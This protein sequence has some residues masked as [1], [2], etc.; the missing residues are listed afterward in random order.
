MVCSTEKLIP[1]GSAG[2]VNEP[3]LNLQ[4]IDEPEKKLKKLICEKQKDGNEEEEK[5]HH[6]G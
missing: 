2:S 1:H 5:D 3:R 6:S 4:N